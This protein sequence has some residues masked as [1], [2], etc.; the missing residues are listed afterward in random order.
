MTNLF[1]GPSAYDYEAIVEKGRESPVSPFFEQEQDRQLSAELEETELVPNRESTPVPLLS[2]PP[3]P[4]CVESDKGQLTTV[5][6][7]PSN[8]AIDSALTM[9]TGLRAHSPASLAR[10]DLE[11]EDR[12]GSDYQQLSTGTSLTPLLR[13]IQMNLD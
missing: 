11:E 7:W 2:P 10:L 5:C 4:L 3:S 8:L 6:E 13:G 9:I 1:L 12:F